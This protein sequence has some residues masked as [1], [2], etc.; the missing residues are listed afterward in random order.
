M[1]EE[2]PL[3]ACLAWRPLLLLVC[4]LWQQPSGEGA[5]VG[6]YLGNPCPQPQALPQPLGLR[7]PDPA[8]FLVGAA[9]DRRVSLS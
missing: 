8:A 9:G 5:R 3:A 6:A 7:V 4:I 2:P 1:Q